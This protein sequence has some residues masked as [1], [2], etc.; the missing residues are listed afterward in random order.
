MNRCQVC[1]A[2][3]TR[4]VTDHEQLPDETFWQV[5]TTSPPWH[6]CDNHSWTP[7]KCQARLVGLLARADRLIA[8]IEEMADDFRDSTSL[9]SAGELRE[10]MLEMRANIEAKLRQIA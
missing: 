1:G 9:T 5:D 8:E 3:A 4:T 10:L 2:P 6:L 7:E